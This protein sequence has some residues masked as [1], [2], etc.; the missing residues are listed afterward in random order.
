MTITKRVIFVLLILTLAGLATSTAAQETT[1]PPLTDP[2]P[3]GVGQQVMTFVD[4]S[5]GDWQLQTY[6]WYPVDKTKGTPLMPGSLVL[7]DAPPERSDAPHPLIVYSHAWTRIDTIPV[8]VHG[9][10][11]WM[12][13]PSADK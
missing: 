10:T 8:S 4:E 11:M 3:Y 9:R 13:L 1:L 6:I 7:K 5:R 2:G 12:L